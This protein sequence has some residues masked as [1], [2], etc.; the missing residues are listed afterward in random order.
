MHATVFQNKNLLFFILQEGYPYILVVCT[1][2]PTW[3][4]MQSVQ[5]N[6]MKHW[7]TKNVTFNRLLTKPLEDSTQ[8]RIGSVGQSFPCHWPFENVE[9]EH[10]FLRWWLIFF[11]QLNVWL[12]LCEG[13]KWLH[14]AHKEGACHLHA[15]ILRKYTNK[16]KPWCYPTKYKNDYLVHIPCRFHYV[17][18]N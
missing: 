7:K 5:I 17:N 6:W 18:W 13:P 16:C 8:V 11:C 4:W 2:L 3:S 12:W 1:S 10:E 15:C 9:D 14:Y